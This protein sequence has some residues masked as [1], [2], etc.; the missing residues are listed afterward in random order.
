M[1]AV[2]LTIPEEY[3]L[4][5]FLS[6]ILAFECIVVGFAAVIPA[7]IK[8]FPVTFLKQFG[9]EHRAAFGAVNRPE[10]GGFPDTG[11]GFYA[12]KLSYKSWFQFNCAWRAH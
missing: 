8:H 6:V 4:V 2:T 9:E 12:D 1:K 11:N 5:V 3:P 10:P 7:R